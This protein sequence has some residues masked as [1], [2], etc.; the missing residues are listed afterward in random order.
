MET[1]TPEKITEI[2][3]ES[4]ESI[5]DVYSQSVRVRFTLRLAIYRQSVLLG[6]EPLGTHGQNIFLY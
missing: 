4:V 2:Y 3:P 6:A 5:P 1:C